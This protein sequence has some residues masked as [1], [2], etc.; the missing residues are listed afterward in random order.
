MKKIALIGGGFIGNFY[1]VSILGQ[2]RKDKI[3]VVCSVPEE[4]AR[5]FAEKWNIPKYTSSMKEAI[6]DPEIDIVVVGLPNYLHKEAILLACKAK[7]H[8]LCTKPLALN[9]A[10]AKEILEAVEKAGVFNGYLE[11]LVYTPKDFENY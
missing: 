6:E 3:H 4:S 10:D 8:I 5:E 9:A 2:R 11:D 1:A 7:K